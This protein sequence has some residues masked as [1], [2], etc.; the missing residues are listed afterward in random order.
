MVK[1]YIPMAAR[2]EAAQLRRSK[3]YEEF[4]KLEFADGAIAKLAI[5]HKLSPSRMRQLL[6]KAR[7]EL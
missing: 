7:D 4:A 2:V 6:I 3:F 1:K 5:R